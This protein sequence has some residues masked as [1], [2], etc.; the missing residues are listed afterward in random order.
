MTESAED[1][2]DYDRNRWS[3][4]RTCLSTYEW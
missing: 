3:R 1:S 4:K 2:W